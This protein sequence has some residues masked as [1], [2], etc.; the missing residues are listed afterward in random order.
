MFNGLY[1]VNMMLKCTLV[2]FKK[3]TTYIQY[4]LDLL[5]DSV[6]MMASFIQPVTLYM[7]VTPHVTYGN[8]QTQFGVATSFDTNCTKAQLRQR[9]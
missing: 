4:K 9:Q 8:I 5:S 1:L 2:C 3:K 7:S 6:K